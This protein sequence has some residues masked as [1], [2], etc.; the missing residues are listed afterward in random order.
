M[1]QPDPTTVQRYLSIHWGNLQT[2]A[3]NEE[4]RA[5]Q[6]TLSKYCEQIS[7]TAASLQGDSLEEIKERVRELYRYVLQRCGKE[8][9]AGDPLLHQPFVL[10][11]YE[12]E[13]LRVSELREQV[14]Q[15]LHNMSQA[16]RSGDITRLYLLLG[17]LVGG[18]IGDACVK[19]SV[20]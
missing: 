13:L 19:R 1:K 12:Q 10:R 3:K 17:G 9:L 20:V 4:T 2:Y 14:P 8:L 5:E 15:V 11:M 7:A 18:V 16:A 6:M